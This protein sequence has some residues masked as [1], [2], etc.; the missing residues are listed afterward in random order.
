MVLPVLL[1]TAGV[2]LWVKLSHRT[3]QPHAQHELF[4]LDGGLGA[5]AFTSQRAGHLW[6]RLFV[7][8]A[9][10][11]LSLG[12]LPTEE[13]GHVHVEASEVLCLPHQLSHC[14]SP[15][16]PPHRLSHCVSHCVFIAV[17]PTVSLSL[18][19]PMCLPPCLSHRL[20]HCVSHCVSLTVSH[21]VSH[22]ISHCLSHCVSL[23][24]SLTVSLTASPRRCSPGRCT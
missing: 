19:I 18:F 2:S 24:F 4:L 5:A 16:C 10:V 13:W 22:R 20:S 15:P 9:E 6:G 17:S 23:T 8:A 7:D 21:C 1:H 14:V 3:L 12:Y 11:P